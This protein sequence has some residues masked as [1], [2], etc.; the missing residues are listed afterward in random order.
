MRYV[1]QQ[2]LVPSLGHF[3]VNDTVLTGALPSEIAKL[4]KLEYLHC[5][6]NELSGVIPSEIGLLTN[7]LH[8]SL[9]ENEI[10]GSLPTEI[11]N[12]G[13][14]DSL[15]LNDNTI[16]GSI[17]S[18]IGRLSN[19]GESFIRLNCHFF[20]FRTLLPSLICF[21][22]PHLDRAVSLSMESLLLTGMIPTEIGRLANARKYFVVV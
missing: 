14:L 5:Y 1:T 20:L 9:D 6:I 16:G 17:P 13:R 12:L 7:L 8:I 4:S 3:V 11:G 22:L 21:L 2:V 19:L 18:E 15:T 10:S